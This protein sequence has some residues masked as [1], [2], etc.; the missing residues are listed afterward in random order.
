[1]TKYKG[2]TIWFTGLSGSGKTT[3]AIALESMLV[4]RYNRVYRLDS[5]NIRLG[6]SK[7]LGF[8]E[9]D[10]RENVRRVGEITKFFSEAGFIVLSSII[11]PYRAHRNEVRNLHE[12]SNLKFIEVFVDCSLSEAEKRDPK[13]LYEKAR[14]GEIKHFTGIDD[15]YE[16]PEKPDIHLKTD[17]STLEEEIA[18]VIE[19]FE[20]HQIICASCLDED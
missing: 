6:I 5:D 2:A 16:P 15:P 11:S 1:M 7:D 9:R 8:S 10:R 4:E 14:K 3:I 17:M 12:S 20:Y 19:Y 18:I 13:R